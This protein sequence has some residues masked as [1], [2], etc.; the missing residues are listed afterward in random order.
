M[1]AKLLPTKLYIPPYRSNLV[2]RQRLIEYLDE[3]LRGKVT[4]VSAPAGFGKTTLLSEWVQHLGR[5]VAWLSLDKNDNDLIRFLTY[6][7]AGLQRINEDIGID[8]KAVLGESQSPKYETML[9]KLINEIENIPE[10]FIVILDDYH[11]IESESVNNA[12]NFLI[13]YQPPMLHLVIS[14]RSDPLLP[15]S[16]LRVRGELSEIRSND[17]RFTKRETAAFLKDLMGFD[18]SPEDIDALEERTEGWV[19][20]LQL[21]ALSMRGRDDWPEF[22]AAFSGSHRYVI[23]YLAD[24][25]MSRQPEEVQVFLRRTSILERF[26]APLCDAVLTRGVNRGTRIIDYLERS[27]LFLIPLDDHREW[28]R[29]HHL[30]VDF[31]RLYLHREEPERIPELHLRASQWFEI[32]GL[33]DEAIQHALAGGNLDRATRLIEG[34]AGSLI[35]R[36]SSNALIHLVNQLPPEMS[37]NFPMLCIWHAWA[38]FFQGRPDAVEPILK[39]AEANR[40]KVPEI[41]IDGYLSTVR[42]YLANLMGDFQKAIDLSKQAIENMSG[43]SP[44]KDTLIFRGAAVIWLG[45]NHRV[46][47]NLDRAKELFTEAAKINEEAGSIYAAV[48]AKSQ[49]ANLAMIL[50]QLHKAKDFYKQG[51]QMAERWADEQEEGQ[52]TLVAASELYLGLGS[53]LYEWNDLIGAASHIR[54]AV[55]LLELAGDQGILGGYRLLAYLYHAEGDYEAAFNLYEKICSLKDNF[56]VRHNN[57]L[58]EPSL[59]QLRILLSRVRPE[60]AHLLTDVAGRVESMGIRPDDEINFATTGYVNEFEYSD[61]ARALI[62]L[63]RVPE[64]LP[65]LERLTEGARSMGRLGDEIRYFV[66]NALAHHALGDLPTALVSL[67]KALTLAKPQGY[68]RL[69]V[70]EGV[71]MAELLQIA[72]SQNVEP[73]YTEKLL[74]AFPDDIRLEKAISQPLVEPLSERELEVLQ[75]MTEGYK[76]KEIAEQLVISVNTVRH[77]TRNIYSKLNVNNRAQAIARANELNLL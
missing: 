4:L 6:L 76:Y 55:K 18:L 68:V 12:L 36:R 3:G 69:F 65:L 41:P 35:V 54:R 33:M 14:G 17:L 40:D 22:I 11:L 31:L 34:I 67:S 45:V 26:C 1:V 53:L 10:K 71:P 7:I 27:N 48:S 70:D 32:E 29:F 75:L 9:T 52:K 25:T 16:R 56:T 49:S 62:A 42:A 59:E 39:I 50:G 30:F 24:E 2:P 20:S 74:A 47:G 15:I 38:L 64:A 21:A 8:I 44:E 46:L 28:Y 58:T 37:Q 63:D 60:M 66:L 61:L 51:F 57:S 43:A 77:H 19:A 5:P 23:D 13:E 72:M 73:D